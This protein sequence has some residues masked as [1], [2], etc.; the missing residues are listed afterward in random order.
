MG[1]TMDRTPSPLLT[2]LY[3][4]TMALGYWRCGLHAR[5]AVFHLS[6]RKHPFDGGYAIAAGLDAALAF[7]EGFRFDAS[8]LAYLS[9]LVGN[10]GRPLFPDDFLRW[11]GGHRLSLDVDA[12]PEGTVVF[13]HEPLLR[14]S[15]A[16]LDAALVETTLLNL[17]N[18]P[19]LIATKASRVVAAA[20]GDPVLEFG[21]RRA[22][23]VDGALTASRAAYLGGCDA[24]SNVLAGKQFGIPVRGTHAHAWV[25]FFGDELEAFRAYADALPNNCTFLVDTYS[26]LDG[27]RHAIQVGHELRARGHRLAG[28]RLDSGDL[29]YLSIEARRLLDE[30]GFPDA[31]VVASNDLDEH[32][33]ESLKLQ[34]ARIGVWGVGTQLVTAFDQ[35]ALGGVYKLGAV[36]NVTEGR[37]EPRLKLSEQRVK[38]S[39]PGVLQVRRYAVDGAPIADQLWDRELGPG[40]GARV[41]DPLDPERTRPIP[42][43][44]THRD[45]LVPVLRGGQR[46][47]E[48]PPLDALRA[49]SRA[50]LASF[51]ESIRRFRNPHVY[52]VGLEP[53]LDAL[54]TRMI[55]EARG[56]S[57]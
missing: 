28:V 8:D 2:D 14:V 27:V 7:L 52:P 35:P 40:E 24:T 53:E 56:L 31:V 34:G 54:R 1:G 43:T 18:F 50:E 9:T 21:L 11:L 15:G 49:A 3:Q 12:V 33:I 4:L 6:F 16:M 30:A 32:L 38:T 17:I 47:Y 48:A 39:I 51:H 41:V 37:W 57:T 5:E 20:K 42:P 45:L 23:G 44:A 26:T 29:A 36:R 19:T 10:D 13:A 22:Q 46:I 55:R 25:M